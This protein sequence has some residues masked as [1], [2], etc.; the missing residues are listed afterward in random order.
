MI[1]MQLFSRKEMTKMKLRLL[2]FPFLLIVLIG[3]KKEEGPTQPPEL[4]LKETHVNVSIYGESDGSIDLTVQGGVSPYTYQWSNGTTTE[5]LSGLQAG[6]YTVTV[7][8]AQ[9]R[10][11]SLNVEITQPWHLIIGWWQW[12]RTDWCE[13]CP[14]IPE[15]L[16]YA[17]TDRFSADSTRYVYINDTLA[18]QEP[19]RITHNTFPG[20]I[21]DSVDM[22][23]LIDIRGQWRPFWAVSFVGRDTLLLTGLFVD[24]GVA[25]Y[26]RKFM[27]TEQE[28]KW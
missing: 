28:M 20:L 26:I 22:V 14:I 21:E 3:C 8:D 7:T 24:A 27:T 4:V 11:A 5:D 18:G 16:G 17:I 10:R 6:I 13:G 2:Y 25:T 9:G 23:N 15:S 12:I 1:T 19:F